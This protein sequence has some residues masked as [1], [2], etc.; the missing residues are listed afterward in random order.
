[1][2]I[3]APLVGNLWL[4]L[5]SYG[6]DPGEII[7]E[8]I[9]RPG[10][11][12]AENDRINFQDYDAILARAASRVPDPAIGLR[13]AEYIHPSHL[14]ALG[15]AW[16][17][18]ST[19]RTAILRSQR[20]SRMFNERLD[21]RVQELSDRLSVSYHLQTSLS[22][23]HVVGDANL[24]VLLKLCRINFGRG[25][26]PV[27][28]ELQRPEPD[29]PSP[30]LEYFGPNVRFGG[31]ENR[32]SISARDA[33]APLTGSNE[34]LVAMNEEVIRRYLLKLDK[35]SIL[36]R[37]R[38]GIIEHLPT[39]RVT[40]EELARRLN[41]SKRTLHRK[42][43]ENGETFRSLVRQVRTGLAEHYIGN[44]KYSVTEIAFLL[45]F[46]D[47]SSFSRAFRDWFGLSPS[48]RREELAA[49]TRKTD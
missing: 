33:D 47:T 26:Q 34:E 4:T 41:I 9:Y 17:A 24:A 8:R 19:L 46:S 48:E 36:N 35:S 45:G 49:E 20:Y 44:D 13:A 7:D 43:R 28:V 40:E 29:D 10:R 14:G 42:L 1:M 32:L 27:E 18:S 15:H 31:R 12:S 5:E 25:L 39:G 11:S 37:A 38:Y 22:R 23:L 6:V 2:S 16:L 21:M 30:W 3:Y